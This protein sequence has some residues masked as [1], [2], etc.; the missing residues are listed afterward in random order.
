MQDLLPRQKQQKQFLSPQRDV[1]DALPLLNH[2]KEEEEVIE[3]S[4][5]QDSAIICLGEGLI[6]PLLCKVF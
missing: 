2:K 6:G 4:D 3:Q 5:S 1:A